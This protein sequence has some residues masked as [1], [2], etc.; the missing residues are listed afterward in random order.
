VAKIDFATSVLK[1]AS[2]SKKKKSESPAVD[3]YEEYE[4]IKV[5]IKTLA[6]QQVAPR[7]VQGPNCVLDWL[8]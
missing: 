8:A 5:Q 1:I 4:R 6:P 7:R 2:A 3:S